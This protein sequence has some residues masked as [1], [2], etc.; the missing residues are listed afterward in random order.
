MMPS[1]DIQVIV[2]YILP[3]PRAKHIRTD[4]CSGQHMYRREK[5]QR[6]DSQKLLVQ[7][8]RYTCRDVPDK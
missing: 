6:K 4:L 3:R 5:L 2:N 8:T 1:E 7:G